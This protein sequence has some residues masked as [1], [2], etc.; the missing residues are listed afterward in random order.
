MIYTGSE[1]PSELFSVEQLK[2]HAVQLAKTHK[3][4]MAPAPDVLLK[5]LAHD[6]RRLRLAYTRISTALTEEGVASTA[7]ENWLLD[8]FYLIE[9]Q[10]ALVRRHLPKGYSRRLPKLQ[11][12]DSVDIP[13][14]HDLAS[15]LIDHTDGRVD[16]ENISAFV[17]AYQTV[18]PLQLGELWAIPIMLQLALLRNLRHVVDSIASQRSEKEQAVVWA[19]R[20]V[21]TSRDEPARLPR[22]LAEFAEANVEFTAQFVEQFQA[23]L[24]QHGAPLNFVKAWV[25]HRLAERGQSLAML[26]DVAGHTAATCQLSIANSIGSLRFING[27]DWRD[28]V[29]N[30][31]LVE[32]VLLSDPVDVYS[33]QDFTTRDRN[34]H[35]I[36]ALAR[37]SEFTEIEVAETAV[38]LAQESLKQGPDPERRG[39]VGY[40]LVN[41]GRRKLMQALSVSTSW[42]LRAARVYPN[43][44]LLTYMGTIGV[45][46]L[47][48]TA[49]VLAL[50][51]AFDV[52]GAGFAFMAVTGLLAASSVAVALVNLTVTVLMPPRTLSRLDFSGGIPDEHRTVVVVPTLLATEQ[53]VEDLLEAMEVRYLGNRDTNLYFALLTDFADAAKKSQ[54]EDEHILERMKL[55][56]EALNERYRRDRPETFL[57]F[58]R[59]RTW[60]EYDGLWSGYERK[61][62]KLEQFNALLRG[63]SRDTFSLII[64]DLDTLQ[65]ARYVITLDTDTQLPRN[66]ARLMVGYMAHPLN[67]PVFSEKAGRVVEG[68]GILQPRTS[69]SLSSANRSLFARLYAGDTGIDPYTREVSDVYQDLFAE[70]SFFG[71][72]IYDVDAFR[73]ATEARFPENLILSHDLIEGGHAR[74]SFIS[75]VDLIEEHPI[76]YAVDASRRH[77]WMRGDWQVAC[78]LL[79]KVPG[80]GKP[81]APW[82]SNPLS[83]I[84]RWKLFDNIRR[85][86][87][88]PALLGFLLGGWW[89]GGTSAWVW[90]AVFLL[91]LVLPAVANALVTLLR[92]PR[93]ALWTLHLR[94]VSEVSIQ[95]LL[96][97]ALTVTFLPYEALLSLN[98]LAYSA[99][100]LPFTRQGL[101]RWQLPHYKQRNRC[102]SVT[103]FFREM[104]AGPAIVLVTAAMMLTPVQLSMAQFLGVSPLLVVWL[105]SPFIAWWISRPVVPRQVELSAR[106]KLFLRGVTR[107]TWHYFEHLNT[108]DD[109]WLIPDN[110]QVYPDARIARRTS[111]T[112]I[113]MSLLANLTA[114]DFGY[115]HGGELVT[116]TQR[117]FATLDR[118]PR[119]R[120][121]FYNWYNTATLEVLPP[122]YV[123]TVDSGNLAGCLLVLRQALAELPAQ[124]VLPSKLFA[125]LEDTLK[126]CLDA[127]PYDRA[128]AVGDACAQLEDLLW[129]REQV[130]LEEMQ[131]ELLEQWLEAVV[132]AAQ[133]LADAVKAEHETAGHDVVDDETSLAD[134]LQEAAQWAG[135]F[136]DQCSDMLQEL[137]TLVPGSGKFTVLPSLATLLK[138]PDAPDAVRQRMDIIAEL[139]RQCAMFLDMDFSFLYDRSSDLLSIGYDVS[140][141][142]LDPSCYDLL[143]SEARLASFL[144]VAWDQ[145]PQ[146][147]WFTLGRLL[148]GQGGDVSLVSWSGSMFE[149]LMPQL[150]LPAYENTLLDRACRA[151]VTRQVAYGHKRGVPWGI[152]E[153]CYHATDA[154]Q[155]YQY[156]AFG[157][158]G[159]GLKRGL[160]DD[161][162]IAPYASA[163]AL[164]VL[165]VTACH[166][167]RILAE[168]GF[169]GEYGFY[170]AIDY[171][172]ARIPR[173]QSHALV[174]CF[175]AHHQGMSMLALSHALLDQPV[176]RR[177]LAD[178]QVRATTLLLQERMP[179]SS[180]AVQ[181]HMAEASAATRQQAVESRA[182]MRVFTNPHTPR[183]EVHLLSNGHY[184]L[185]VT[186]AGG[187]YSHCEGVALTRWREDSTCDSRGTFIYLRDEDTG[188]YWSAAHQPVG[189]KAGQYE[190]IFVQAR[191]EY[192]RRAQDIMTHTELCV[193]PEDDVEIRRVTLTNQSSRIRHIELT[194]YAEVVLAPINADLAHPAFSNLFIRTEILPERSAILCMRRPRE[195]GDPTRW[196]FHLLAVPR[197]VSDSPS[198]ETDRSLFIGRGRTSANPRM[199]VAGDDNSNLSNTD[200][201]V[202]DPIVAIRRTLVL[203][204]DE[205]AFA[206]IIT[207]LADTREQAIELIERYSDHYVVERAFE[208]AWFR[209][210]EVTRQLDSNEA[211][212]QLFGRLASSV[213]FASARHRAPSGTVV[214]NCLG[215]ANLWRFSISGDL[216]IVLV[217]IASSKRIG[218]LRK[219]LQAHAYWRMK[220]LRCDLVIVN[221]DFSGYRADLH[222]EITGLV[223]RSPDLWQMDRPGGVFLRRTEEL[224]EDERVLLQSVARVV[225]DDHVETLSSLLAPAVTPDQLPE[226]HWK[227]R[228]AAGSGELPVQTVEF[229]NGLGGF[230]QDG[231]EYVISLKP[232]QRSPA[233]WVNV[234]ASPHIGTVVSES[235]SAYTWVDNA[236]EL[237]LTQW[238]N[239]PVSDTTAEAFYVRDEVSGAFWSPTAL[240]APSASEYR[241]RHGFGYSVFEQLCD[242]LQV[243]LTVTVAMDEPVKIAILRLHNQSGSTRKLS[244]TGYWE[245]VLGDWRHSNAMQIV[246]EQDVPSGAVVARN[247]YNRTFSDRVCFAAVSEKSYSVSGCRQEFIGRNGTLAAPAALSRKQLSNRTGARLDP[248]AAI[249]AAVEVGAGETREIVFVFG[250]AGGIGAARKLVQ[251]YATVAGAAQA[252]E[253]TQRYWQHTLGAVRV[254]TPDPALDVLTNGW[255][256]YQTLSCRMWGR[257]GYYQ[258]GGAYG[259]RDQLQDSLALLHAE[260]SL[261]RQQLLRCASRQFTKGDVQHWWHPPGGQ[262]VRTHFSDDY[263]WLP[264]VCCHYVH[265]TGDNAV[266]DE[267]VHFL[268][269]RELHAEEEAS[270][271]QPQ[272]STEKASLYEHC[273]RAIRH[274]LRFGKHGLP[275]MGCGDWNDGMNRVGI[276]GQGES[277]WLA[278]FLFDTL[279]RFADLAEQ[280]ADAAFAS[281]CREQAQ[282]LR[283]NIEAK[284]WDG[285]WYRRA[286]FDDGTPLGSSQNEECSIDAISQAWA[287]LSGAGDKQRSEQA[288]EAVYRKLVRTDARL[289]QLLDPPFD[290]SSL[291]PGYIKGY[292]PGVRENGGQYTHAAIWTTMAF[293]RMGQTGRAWS[294][295]DMLNPIRHGD[296]PDR[297]ATYRVEPYVMSADVYGSAPHT[298]RG[299]WSWYTGAAGWMYRLI[300]ET[301]LGLH[302]QGEYL[303]IAPGVPD[304]WEQYSI[305][306][307]H[308]ETWYHIVVEG[309]GKASEGLPA[310]EVDG[311]AIDGKDAGEGSGGANGVRFRLVDDG[312][313]HQVVVRIGSGG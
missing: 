89:L 88:A 91:L 50:F 235:G 25:E 161:L 270:Y 181:P 59:P 148:S 236:H 304:T 213:V 217:Q 249:Q 259:F 272:R 300:T 278:W 194:S 203:S 46:T 52:D 143:A 27:M 74:S 226:R 223:N 12:A 282:Q 306:Y 234:I 289:I 216:P 146:E 61:R 312:G 202:L 60:N 136:V 290:S 97:A 129:R 260:P 313:K 158:P 128:K 305:D 72:G 112:N 242:D 38:R 56:I 119:H 207:G 220:G 124:P 266:L 224:S 95:P 28:F 205:S 160:A 183:P 215:Q 311:V 126:R 137:R 69:I 288:M 241:C 173:G 22:L 230:S 107:R 2:R 171:S 147:H 58:H 227:Q 189:E 24:A 284:A 250:A 257:S 79:P 81:G 105:V 51:S 103:D 303:C 115:V 251:R 197:S 120:G 186:H 299:G 221:E 222:D 219:I 167:L 172:P 17:S 200:G 153:S 131:V 309:A 73:K 263:L 7:A 265:A 149:Y 170:E 185:M 92:K 26:T 187:S 233:P 307:R 218:L 237:R 287:V 144:L 30:L 139:Q 70:G 154:E 3:V 102:R 66:A 286:W 296:T 164:T 247:A 156:R 283:E 42:Q 163:L 182:V 96:R 179:R 29:E 116:L 11:R 211:D 291:E 145:V 150:F 39:H 155:T 174:Q 134:M 16:I 258:S 82:Q 165:P 133:A 101:L 113:G 240:P 19:E 252:L 162:V 228:E 264:W 114:L 77:R 13:R 57:L 274:G 276:R 254:K 14:V 94:L 55:G 9:Q 23:R 31:S 279:Q 267:M 99:L 142:R 245:L 21:A 225:V 4:S 10:V 255:L 54:P 295:F 275:L 121:H 5:R 43:A 68:F 49:G 271:G 193:S 298:G 178:P 93:L 110:L 86:L 34:R 127:L 125:G 65:S 140:E 191:A 190:A 87:V 47:L 18:S 67:R 308:G 244:A 210:Q 277:V 177:L 141:R 195:A 204:E 62:G 243:S 239:D 15:E 214:R 268:E 20:M 8:N 40:Y 256:L 281:E 64:G 135:A 117:T 188:R 159:L 44:R 196:M 201:A 1:Q 98:A 37:H 75:D 78:W 32:Q 130:P 293:A 269:G 209:S 238:H 285:E 71:K 199:L 297:V 118:L 90:T 280:R 261:T 138:S 6:E 53:D 232:G 168:K 206:Q 132:S 246:T 208:L 157:V 80:A 151:A 45:V 83:A 33:R 192:R 109:H 175:M 310:L 48:A 100:R 122:R 176:Q 231:R 123:S 104:W 253:A 84:S 248:C 108:A 63:G 36:E 302:R 152:S 301:L 35:A 166:N 85:N 76:S 184:H 41:R 198:Y 294:L 169:L 229:D 262:G 292:P 180:I 106:Q 273:V 111:P 212:A